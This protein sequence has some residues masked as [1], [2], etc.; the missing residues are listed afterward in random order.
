MK[1]K[2]TFYKTKLAE[3]PAAEETYYRLATWTELKLDVI[4]HT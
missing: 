2:S 1:K 3:T 4:K